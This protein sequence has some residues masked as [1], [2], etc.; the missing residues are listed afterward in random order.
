VIAQ[1]LAGVGLALALGAPPVDAPPALAQ[2]SA[3]YD[4]FDYEAVVAAGT[5]LGESDAQP[6]PVRARAWLY[7][8]IAQFSGGAADRARKKRA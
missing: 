5:E 2:L 3:A 7:V 6:A 8:G 4:A 1:L